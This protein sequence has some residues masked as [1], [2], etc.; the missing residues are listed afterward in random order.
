MAPSAAERITLRLPVRVDAA[1]A[2]RVYREQ[3]PQVAR[4]ARID[5]AGVESIG[6]AGLALLLE[7]R[8]AAQRASGNAPVIINA[9]AHLRALCDAHRVAAGV[10]S[11]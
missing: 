5:L 4:L 11:A 7:L 2:A 3:L 1:V 6:S 9:P 8:E 10:L